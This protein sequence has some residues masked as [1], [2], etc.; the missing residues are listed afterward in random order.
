M[1]GKQEGPVRG[2]LS[3]CSWASCLAVR[4]RRLELAGR[5][6]LLLAPVRVHVSDLTNHD[7]LLSVLFS[8]SSP[9]VVPSG[10]LTQ[11]DIV[12]DKYLPVEVEIDG[13]GPLEELDHDFGVFSS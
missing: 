12:G 8:H 9:P 3:L 13:V 6:A 2:P 10:W 1:F 7:A 11:G 5:A 4:H